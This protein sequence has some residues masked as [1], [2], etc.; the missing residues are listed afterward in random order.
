LH[1]R[2]GQKPQTIPYKP[3][4]E[5]EGSF[6]VISPKGGQTVIEFDKAVAAVIMPGKHPK[7]ADDP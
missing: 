7:S 3:L 4:P 5:K 6:V 2:D 1:T